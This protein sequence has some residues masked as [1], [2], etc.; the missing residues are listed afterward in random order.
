MKF[1]IGLTFA[2]WVL[3]AVSSLT[4]ILIALVEAAL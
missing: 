1:L 2:A 3:L 4:G